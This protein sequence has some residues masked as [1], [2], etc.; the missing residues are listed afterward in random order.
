MYTC[1]LTFSGTQTDTSYSL[2]VDPA[3]PE[4]LIVQNIDGEQLH[5]L[6]DKDDN[7]VASE[8]DSLI[9]DDG[10]GN[11]TFVTL[12]TN[13]SLL[14]KVTTL[15][16]V[17]IKY[18]WNDDYSGVYVTAVSPNGSFQVTVNVNLSDVIDT[19]DL[20]RDLGKQFP[21]KKAK[22]QAKSTEI[23]EVPVHV[24]HCDEPEPNAQVYAKALLNYDEEGP[25]WTGE[26]TYRAIKTENSGVYHIQLYTGTSS[27]IG[28]VVED[29]C[30]QVV[31]V[32]G[33]GCTVLSLINLKI[34]NRIC[35][36]IASGAEVVTTLIPGD[37]VVVLGACNA[38]FR[39][40]RFYCDTVGKSPPGGKSLADVSCDSISFI[41]GVIDF[42]N[43]DTIFLQP[44]AVFPAGNTVN[45]N[46]LALNIQPGLSGVLPYSFTITDDASVP[47][48]TSL[49]VTPED[50]EPHESYIVYATYIC[51][52]P[53]VHVNMHIIGTD[54]YEE[55]TFCSGDVHNC[56]LYVP[57]A[58]E[59]VYDIV[60]VTISDTSTGYSFTRQVV[61]VF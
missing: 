57:G 11:T 30:K 19:T 32:L 38:G 51:S 44:S 41:D 37:F 61:I 45:A 1:V 28:Q 23:A 55:T 3:N 21:D 33:Y 36:A 46:G 47:I 16:G 39:A 25:R 18:K 60:T 43:E 6:G 29:V 50:P 10:K 24:Y 8:V 7:G 40:A 22:R 26:K 27:D 2:N 5:I 17:E 42:V 53:A 48:I 9:L 20:K 14:D 56:N 52:G 31:K 35:V 59:L 12:N 15:S 49:T 54:G 34:Q 58:D 4:I 13:N